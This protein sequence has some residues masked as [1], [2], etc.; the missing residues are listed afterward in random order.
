MNASD[1]A[2]GEYLNTRP[3]GDG[4]R[5]RDRGRPVES[6][7]GDN[8][9]VPTAYLSNAFSCCQETQ[10]GIAQTNV[11]PPAKHGNGGGSG[12]MVS[13]G[14]L[15][16]MSCLQIRGVG[17]SKSDDRRFKSYNGL[18]GPHRGLNLFA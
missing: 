16:P 17:Q 13:D 10:L 4:C 2:G 6:S 14:S 9:Q 7:R 8:W 11:Q 1:A 15:H 3:G 12:S 18:R 5:G